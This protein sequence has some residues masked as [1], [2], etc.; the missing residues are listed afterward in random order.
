MTKKS[1]VLTRFQS[2]WLAWNFCSVW[3]ELLLDCCGNVVQ[4]TEF[5]ADLEWLGSR[6]EWNCSCTILACQLFDLFIRVE[7]SNNSER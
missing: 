4:D 6:W 7:V 2:G 1:H 3:H 5:E